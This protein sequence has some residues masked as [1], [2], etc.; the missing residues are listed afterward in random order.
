MG[1]ET[2]QEWATNDKRPKASITVEQF[3][4]PDNHLD[5]DHIACLAK[6]KTSHNILQSYKHTMATDPERW[7]I[8][9]NAEMETLKAKHNWDLVKPPIGA[10]IMDSM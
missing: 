2:G 6:T 4:P 5:K 9:M 7:M 8:P 3:N 10:N 1:K